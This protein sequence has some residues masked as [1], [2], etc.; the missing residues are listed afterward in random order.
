[1]PERTQRFNKISSKSTSN[2]KWLENIK[3]YVSLRKGT[4]KNQVDQPP[5]RSGLRKMPSLKSV[6]MTLSFTG[7]W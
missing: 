3:F 5:P 1:M 2:L 4:L 6:D 7:E